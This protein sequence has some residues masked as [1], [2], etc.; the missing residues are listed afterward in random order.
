MSYLE[1]LKAAI[2]EGKDVELF[3]I[4][5]EESASAI[6][7]DD[8]IDTFTLESFDI[9]DELTDD[10]LIDYQDLDLDE[11]VITDELRLEYGL[12]LFSNKNKLHSSL[13]T[14]SKPIFYRVVEVES[15]NYYIAYQVIC[16]NHGMGLEVDVNNNDL[17]GIFTSR[18]EIE[19]H[20]TDN[21][22]LGW[23]TEDSK[24]KQTQR[25]YILKNWHYEII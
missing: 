12:V 25:G 16:M 5:D 13:E 21:G 8:F 1:N 7:T 6:D 9:D 10:Y 23:F 14:Y 11:T 4:I 20:L 15:Q 18:D 24:L 3:D 17:I 19:R 22:Y 2:F